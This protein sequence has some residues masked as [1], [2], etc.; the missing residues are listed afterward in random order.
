MLCRALPCLFALLAPALHADPDS[1]LKAEVAQRVD[2]AYPQLAA[3]YQDLHLHPELSMLEHRTAAKLAAA[4]RDAGFDVTEHFGGTGIVAVLRNGAGPVLMIRSDMDALPVEEQTGLP[5]ASHA[6]MAD[7]AGKD[8]PV[9]HACG[10]DIHMSVLAGTART[11]AAER[12]HWHGTLIL[13]GQPAE[14]RV[15]GARAMLTAGLFRKF[16]TPNYVIAL[17][18]SAALPAGKVGFVEGFA[19]ANVN[20][21]T[22]KVRGV[23][24]HGAYPHLTKDPI[25]LAAQIVLDLQTIV[26]REVRPGDPAVVTVGSIQ[27]GTKNNIIP[28][29]V[30]LLLT[31]RSYTDETRARLVAS[32][33]RICRG[34]GIAAG[35]PDDLLPE[36]T[37]DE[38]QSVESTYSDPKLTRRVRGAVTAWL[39]TDAVTTVDPSMAS[40]DFGQYGRTVEHIPICFYWLGAVAPAAYA[41]SL[42]TGV[43]LPALHSSRFAPL[44]EPTIKTGIAAMTAAALDLLN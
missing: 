26:S 21:V 20:T 31:L 22:V 34:A 40:E 3:F 25:V 29:D 33:K 17:H 2:A 18:D 38:S 44:P 42:R 10:H 19:M 8:Q 1:R 14:E 11:L 4:L 43:A 32:V 27:G 39:G 16:P 28:D 23:G 5:Y 13:I 35:L 7:I 41:E 15:V 37:V 12:A 6:H 24:G 36:V 9:M 30:T